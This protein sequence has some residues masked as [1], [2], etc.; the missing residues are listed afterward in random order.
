MNFG[1]SPDKNLRLGPNVYLIMYSGP[2]PRQTEP[3]VVFGINITK[4]HPNPWNVQGDMLS[5]AII[6]EETTLEKNKNKTADK[7]AHFHVGLSV[8][9]H[10]MSIITVVSIEFILKASSEIIGHS[11]GRTIWLSKQE[12]CE[13]GGEGGTAESTG[14]QNGFWAPRPMHSH[15]LVCHS[16]SY[17]EIQTHKRGNHLKPPS[18]QQTVD[19]LQI[20]AV[21]AVK[22]VRSRLSGASICWS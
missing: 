17:G 19:F 14:V 13:G 16:K 20:E 18:N 22:G 10:R 7:M 9:V 6:L 21:D 5:Y 1:F 11:L 12:G 4:N 15:P 3:A 8:P 2:Q